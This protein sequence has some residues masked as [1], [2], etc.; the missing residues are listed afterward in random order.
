MTEPTSPVAAQ[1]NTEEKLRNQV[2]N[3]N[4]TQKQ[5]RSDPKVREQNC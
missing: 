3:G 1:V 4:G 5:S 2:K